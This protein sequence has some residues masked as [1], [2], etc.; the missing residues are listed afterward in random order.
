MVKVSLADHNSSPVLNDFIAEGTD[1]NF[2]VS[3]NWRGEF[4]KI[5]QIVYCFIVY[6][7]G[8]TME[9]LFKLA[10]GSFS[11]IVGDQGTVNNLGVGIAFGWIHRPDHTVSC[12]I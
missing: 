2:P 1:V 12:S 7:F 6:Y 8:I 9:K 3:H 10:V 5:A 4:S 11:S